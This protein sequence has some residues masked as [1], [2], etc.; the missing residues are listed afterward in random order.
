MGQK[1]TSDPIVGAYIKD[2]PYMRS[3]PM[4]SLTFYNG[5]NDQIIKAYQ[6]VINSNLKGGSST[7][8]TEAKNIDKILTNFSAK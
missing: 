2:A 8:Q 5:L 4:S 1:I 7:L 6:D 3:A